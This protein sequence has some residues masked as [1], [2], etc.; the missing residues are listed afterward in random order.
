MN[1]FSILIADRAPDDA[2]ALPP[3]IARNIAS[4]QDHH[5]GLPHR[6][7]DQQAIRAFLRGHMEADVCRAYEALLP[8]AYRADLARLCLLHEFGGAYADLSVFFHAGMPLRSGK[9]VVFRDRAVDAPWIVSNTVIGAPARLPAFEAAIRMIVANCGKRHRGVSSLCPTGPVLFGKAIALHC[10]PEQI[11]LGEVIN[12]AQRDSVETLAFVDATNGSLVAYRTKPAAGLGGLGV[13]A[14]VN[15]YNDFY[16]AGLVYASDFP[17]AIRADY[18]ARH[19]AAG[20]LDGQHWL[21][22]RKGGAEALAT[23]GLCPLPMPFA[24]GRH[25]VLLELADATPGAVALYATAHGTGAMLAHGRGRIDGAGP[26]AV[27]MDLDIGTSR[28][29]V[30]IGILA[31]DGARLRVAGL[32]IERLQADQPT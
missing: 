11:H 14:G 17:V 28:K 21:L 8:Y 1:L 27:A 12:V 13:H 16:Y 26:A 25:R 10:E 9:L 7:Y 23:V 31:E 18:L 5:P 4:F 19:G 32:R 2:P 20:T 24:A 15:N 30:V 3:A 29:D 6:L 22:E